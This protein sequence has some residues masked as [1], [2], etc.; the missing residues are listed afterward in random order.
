MSKVNILMPSC[1]EPSET[2]KY[3]LGG[4]LLEY[5]NKVENKSSDAFFSF[6]RIDGR[7]DIYIRR[8]QLEENSDENIFFIFSNDSFCDDI[9]NTFS[10]KNSTVE[11]LGNLV[12]EMYDIITDKAERTI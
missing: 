3:I 7:T 2:S 8:E 12:K 10:I 4:R 9:K 5:L 6:D 11:S 1:S